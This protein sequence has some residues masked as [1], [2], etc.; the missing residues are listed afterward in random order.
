MK[1]F[2]ITIILIIIIVL[3][4]GWFIYTSTTDSNVNTIDDDTFTSD[5]GNGYVNN[6]DNNLSFM[7]LDE[8]IYNKDIM[9]ITLTNGNTIAVK[10]IK[11]KET[12]S[13]ENREIFNFAENRNEENR[14]YDLIYYDR[15]DAFQITIL[16]QPVD[17]ARMQ[18]EIE[19][20]ETLGIQIATLCDMRLFVRSD[21]EPY[22]GKELG[23][24]FC[25]D[26]VELP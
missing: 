15:Y 17:Q 25:R 20:S 24:S 14:F 2:F 13:R 18:A 8:H 21:L 19:L 5:V 22:K 4:I 6:V 3:S 26:S 9:S 12:V 7:E 16:K 1:Y 10:N 23:I 11:N